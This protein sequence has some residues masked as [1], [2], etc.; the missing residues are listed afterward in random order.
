MMEA[1]MHVPNAD[2]AI[3]LNPAFHP[4]FTNDVINPLVVGDMSPPSVEKLELTIPVSLVAMSDKSDESDIVSISNAEFLATVFGPHVRLE[5]PFVCNLSGLPSAPI[6]GSWAGCPWV[7]GETKTEG[8]GL[9]WYF[10]LATFK[11]GAEGKYRRQKTH[12]AGLHA[13]MLDDIGT[14]AAERSRLD[15]LP[16]SWLIETSPGNYQAGY[17]L[18]EPLTDGKLAEELVKAIIAAGLCDK[19]ADGPLARYARLPAAVNGKHSPAFVC[20]LVEWRPERRFTPAEIIEGLELKLRSHETRTSSP[21]API[22][23]SSTNDHVVY[24]PRASENPVIAALRE[25]G[26]YGVSL[27]S[28]KH[29]IT[30]PWVD[31]HTDGIDSGTAYFEPEAIHPIGGFKCLHGHCADRKI[32][33]LLEHLSVEKVEAKHRATIRA[34]PGELSRIVDAAERE[35]A[36]TGQHYQRSGHIV[37]I[38]ND[39]ATGETAIR[40]VS[41]SGLLKALS[42]SVNWEC[43]D[44]RSRAFKP[45]DPPGKYLNVLS[46]PQNQRHLPVLKGLARQPYLRPNK[47]VMS[48]AGYDAATGM[49]GIF[50]EASFM[51]PDNPTR[52][53]AMAALG[54]LTDLLQEF[55]FATENDRAAAFSAILTA[56][57]RPSLAQAPM[58]HVKAPQIASGKSYLT[59]LIASFASPSPTPATSFPANEEECQKLLLSKFMEGP[60]VLCFD[61]LTTD[62]LPHKSLCSALTDEYVSGRILGISKTATVGTRVLILSSGNNVDPIRDMSRRCI[63]IRLDPGCETPAAREFHRRPVED[64]QRERGRYVSLTLTIIRAWIV[65]GH[66]PTKCRPLASYTTWSD[67]VRQ[68]LLWLGQPDPADSVFTAMTVDPNSET[69]GRLLISWSLEFGKAPTMVRDVVEAANRHSPDPN[70]VELHEVISDIADER[71]QIS[72]KRLGKWIGRNEGRIVGGLRFVKSPMIRNAVQWQ[73]ESVSSVSTV[74]IAPLAKSVIDETMSAVTLH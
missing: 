73:V 36:A 11:P 21:P 62:L 20:Q 42:E 13:I 8:I 40:A 19:G 60:A 7:P 14:K 46:E 29:Q 35:L 65:S 16:P 2:K 64:V 72:R 22:R 50:D 66:S 45:V 3:D 15:V 1:A 41:Q 54:V 51:V 56:A 39:P 49:F 47:T 4:T 26:L 33:A 69:L 6:A 70:R 25:R 31:E 58:F 52:D 32:G 44:L 24:F 63:T 53:D 71:G 30:C 48:Q 37:S 10:S 74:P 27:G 55:S 12:F 18:V 61:N 38:F 28:G 17:L 23:E 9:N 43:F 59:N 34:I 5:R 57:I 68:A 67:L